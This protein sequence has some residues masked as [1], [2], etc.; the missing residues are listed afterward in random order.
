MNGFA[1]ACLGLVAL[2]NAAAA[3]DNP[4][5][6]W[7][8][9]RA[10]APLTVQEV[11]TFNVRGTALIAV[12]S[13]TFQS[14]YSWPWFDVPEGPARVVVFDDDDLAA[15]SKAAILFSESPPV[16]GNEVGVMPVDT[17]TGAFLDRQTAKALDDLSAAMGTECNLYDCLMAEQV[18]ES[19]FAQM[20]KLPDG[21]SYP[22]FSTGFGDGAYPVYLLRDADG[23]PTAAFVDFLGVAPTFDWM[24]PPTCP[25]PLS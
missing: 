7:I 13:L 23:V 8:K 16:C 9:D 14:S 6:A 18:P 20:I 17:G 3:E 10:D 15:L 19:Q 2:T 5:I 1:S 11:G 25:R 21:T 24:T 12:D 4:S 22:A